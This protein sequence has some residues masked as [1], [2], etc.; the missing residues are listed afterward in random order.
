MMLN[1]IAS[2][3]PYAPTATTSALMFAPALMDWMASRSVTA[4]L[5]AT[6]SPVEVTVTVAADT[7]E[8]AHQS[9]AA[10]IKCAERKLRQRR[11]LMS[12]LHNYELS[13]NRCER[14]TRYYAK[15]SR[16]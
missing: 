11:M 3:V 16:T 10:H 12:S 5:T 13:G 4:P 2:F 1:A 15:L 9:K 8:L 14:A 6:V 7:A